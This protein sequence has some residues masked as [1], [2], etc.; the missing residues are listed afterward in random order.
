MLKLKTTQ[1]VLVGDYLSSMAFILDRLYRN[2]TVVLV[3]AVALLLQLSY[4][5]GGGSSLGSGQE[6]ASS[7]SID[8][9]LTYEMPL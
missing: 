6:V 3:P 8:F 5:R 9:S 1:Q 2:V 7:S 4:F